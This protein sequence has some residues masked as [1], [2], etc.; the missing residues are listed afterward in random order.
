MPPHSRYRP[1]SETYS[2]PF[3]VPLAHESAWD[4]AGAPLG[5]FKVVRFNFLIEHYPLSGIGYGEAVA[6]LESPDGADVTDRRLLR[7]EVER[8]TTA[9]MLEEQ[10]LSSELIS[11]IKADLSAKAANLADFSFGSDLETHVAMSFKTN[12]SLEVREGQKISL[13]REVAFNIK[14]GSPAAVYAVPYALWGMSVRLNHVDFLTVRYQRKTRGLR[15]E[16]SKDPALFTEANAE[17]FRSHVNIRESG[18]LL[19]E[20]RYW[21]AIGD[22]STTLVPRARHGEDQ[23]NPAHVE[24]IASPVVDRRYYGRRQF[25]STPSLYKIAN[26]AFPLKKTQRDEAWTNDELLEMLESEPSEI[27]Y[28]WEAHRRWR[29]RRA[30]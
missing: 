29:R 23:I 7:Y 20:F 11:H 14:G 25:R 2:A 28:I 27:A 5:P 18:L 3:S 9:S 13:E 4:G 10:I 15:V 8:V 26:A 1:T 12:T 24:F 16:R 19:G 22:A 30:R 21:K 17:R 6:H